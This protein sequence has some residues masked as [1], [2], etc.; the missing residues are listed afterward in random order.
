M[1]EKGIKKQLDRIELYTMLA[2]KNVL[3]IT[4]AAFIL[5]MTPQGVRQKVRDREIAAYKPNHNRLYFQKKDL[6]RWML[7]NRS[8][9][10]EELEQAANRHSV[11]K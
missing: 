5:G 10:A 2:A 1:D 9:T 7:Q 11:Y 4:E 6:E 8:R 3:N